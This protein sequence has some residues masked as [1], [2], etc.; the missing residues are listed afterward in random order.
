MREILSRRNNAFVIEFTFQTVRQIFIFLLATIQLF[1]VY[2]LS[3][4]TRPLL[5]T[6]TVLNEAQAPIPGVALRVL[7]N[8]NGSITNSSGEYSII[9][10]KPGRYWIEISS[11]GYETKQVEIQIS[12]TA[13]SSRDFQLQESAMELGEVVVEAESDKKTIESGS[14]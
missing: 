5:L 9:F 4:Q 3:A 7:N 2:G 6:G 10:E 8:T 14:L 13:S 1:V 11:V 12:A